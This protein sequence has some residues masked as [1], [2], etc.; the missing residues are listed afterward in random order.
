MKKIKCFEYKVPE[1]VKY[2]INLIETPEVAKSVRLWL[3]LCEIISP[4]TL[5]DRN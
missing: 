5:N 3:E 2:S 1:G 4:T